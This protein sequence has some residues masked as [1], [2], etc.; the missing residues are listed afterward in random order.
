MGMALRM[1]I[2]VNRFALLCLFFVGCAGTAP[3]SYL[4]QSPK[5]VETTALPPL[6]TSVVQ[7]KEIMLEVKLHVGADGSV[8]DFLWIASSR[9]RE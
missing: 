5:L 9:N 8:D 3:P 7:K 1:C 6:P 4:D 2:M